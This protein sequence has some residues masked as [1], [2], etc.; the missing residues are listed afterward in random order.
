[1]LK[2]GNLKYTDGKTVLYLST[3]ANCTGDTTGT[4]ADM[5][6]IEVRGIPHRT[7]EQIVQMFFENTKRSGGGEIS[8][9]Q[10]NC[11]TGTAVITFADPS[12][13]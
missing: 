1:M 12:G 13:M 3:P 11:V 2:K 7:N 9:C 10:F 6:T 5:Q 8:S 4:D